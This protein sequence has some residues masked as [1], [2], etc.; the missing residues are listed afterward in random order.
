MPQRLR[1]V[2]R[3]EVAESASSLL[4]PPTGRRLLIIPGYRSQQEMFLIE[5]VF[6]HVLLVVDIE[7][8]HARGD[9]VIPVFNPYGE[10]VGL[11]MTAEVATYERYAH[12]ESRRRC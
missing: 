3:R 12:R 9:R 8:L 2:A 11:R 1:C 6:R 10:S 4:L 7:V 5:R